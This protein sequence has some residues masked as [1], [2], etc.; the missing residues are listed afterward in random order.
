MEMLEG[1]CSTISRARERN[2]RNIV[3]IMNYVNTEN[4]M[5]TG[6]VEMMDSMQDQFKV[7]KWMAK[8][9]T[10]ERV[11]SNSLEYL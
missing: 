9:D 1:T 4:I 6:T 3:S 2:I 11:W 7:T 5:N 10:E 8:W